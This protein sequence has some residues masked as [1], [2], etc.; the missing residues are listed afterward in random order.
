M[1][2]PI[3]G[4]FRAQMRRISLQPP[5]IPYLS[6]LTGTWI[7]AAEA[8]DPGY[9]ADHLRNTVRF[10][11]CVSELLRQPG[12]IM[13][14]VGPG[15]TLASLIR[16]Q[17]GRSAAGNGAK[18]LSSLRRREETTPDTVVLLNT[19]GQ[20]WIGGQTVNWPALHTSKAAMRVP[21]PTYPFQRQ[22]FWIDRDDVTFKPSP[23]RLSPLLASGGRRMQEAQRQYQ[24]GAQARRA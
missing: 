9:W 13:I 23:E 5:R 18:V 4:S 8:T 3:L 17:S 6:N 21:L 11:D 10:S 7:T 12:R 19:L 16:E 22:R 20:L 2:D 1:M 24:K 14:E 15:Q